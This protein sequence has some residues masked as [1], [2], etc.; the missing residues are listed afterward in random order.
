[1]IRELHE[2]SDQLIDSFSYLWS[3]LIQLIEKSSQSGR[4][5]VCLL[6][7]LDEC[8]GNSRRRFTDS[9]IDL[10]QSNSQSEYSVKFLITSRPYDHILRYF[11]ALSNNSSVTSTI[12]LNGE[13]EEEV[14]KIKAEIDIVVRS[15]VDIL[16][17]THRLTDNEAGALVDALLSIEHRTYLWVALAID[18]IDTS[19]F[20]VQT[21]KTIVKTIPKDLDDAY[22]K[23]LS[24]SPNASQTRRILHIVV[25]AFEPLTIQQLSLALTIEKVYHSTKEIDLEPED[26]LKIAVRDLCG[27]FV[28]IV[29]NKVYLLHQTAKEFLICSE[30]SQAPLSSSQYSRGDPLTK[31]RRSTTAIVEPSWKQSFVPRDSHK[32]LAEICIW[33]LTLDLRKLELDVLDYYA[34]KWWS[35]HFRRSNITID[36]AIS[37]QATALCEKTHHSF[38]LW[39][40]AVGHVCE[41]IQLNN[42][43]PLEVS[44]A[45]GLLPVV[46]IQLAIN[47]TNFDNAGRKRQNQSPRCWNLW[48]LA[49]CFIGS[50]QQ[51]EHEATTGQE[52]YNLAMVAAAEGGHV[53]IVKLLLARGANVNAQGGKYGSALQAASVWGRTA[54]VELLLAKA[55]NINAQGGQYGSALQ[56]ASVRGR[57]AT[58]ELL[59]ARGANI[60]AQGGQY[61][62]ALQAASDNG[63]AAIV[64]LLLAKGAEKRAASP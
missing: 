5:V 29:D 53:A 63:H 52:H 43:A 16:S 12:W 55:A 11:K 13:E 64:E 39:L 2:G 38:S 57:T 27:L 45:L 8:E 15:R 46:K 37:K 56:A 20:T 36:D 1:M 28:V 49:G 25:G 26:R 48:H 62:S 51:E 23:I 58:V 60:N 19:R 31:P 21:I 34:G 22:E 42:A 44:S 61:G 3:L 9:L 41:T 59:L 10:Y 14:D 33:Y 4:E 35:H 40:V 54:T 17:T 30:S 18:F 24:R 47:S 32:V 50:R 7:A 6:D